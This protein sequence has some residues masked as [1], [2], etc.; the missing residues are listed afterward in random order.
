MV[1][2]LLLNEEGTLALSGSSDHT[3]RLWDLG[4]QRCLQTF[5]VHTDSVWA[6]AA[7]PDLSLVY[8]GG[9]DRCVYRWTPFLR[10]T[11][12][13]TFCFVSVLG[14]FKIQALNSSRL[15][16]VPTPYPTLPRF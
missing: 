5:A 10:G 1:R 15:R 9:R 8:S 14:W 2:A 11:T 12:F 6:L 3:L 4:Q 7:A 16:L 13:W